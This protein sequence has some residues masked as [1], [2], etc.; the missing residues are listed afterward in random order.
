VI[1]SQTTRFAPSP[2]GFLHVGG[3]RTA[4]FNWLHARHL[5]GRFILRIEDT[6]VA[7]ST[8]ESVQA[9][10][11]ALEWLGIDWDEGPFYQSRRMAVYSEYIQ[12]LVAAGK[13][14]YCTCTP[15]QIDAM[16]ERA[17]ADRVQAAL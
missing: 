6:D 1:R 2:T 15:D 7:R 5:G 17:R 4:L 8:R 3:A 9:I 16:R 13:A 11:D 12:K 10:F 14:Y